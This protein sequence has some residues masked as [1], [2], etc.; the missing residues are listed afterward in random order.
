MFAYF[1]RRL[2]LMIPTF[3]GCTILVFLV[4]QITPGGPIDQI[5][6]QFQMQGTGEISGGGGG[7]AGSGT[8]IPEEALTELKK[9]FDL[10]KPI[11]VRYWNWLTKTLTGDFGK[12]YVYGEPVMDVITSRFPISVYFG[13]IGFILSYLVCIPLGIIKAI[14]NGTP[15]DIASSA[16][17]YAGYAIPGFALGIL[18]L[19]QFGDFGLG[20]FPQA[21]FRSD[22]WDYL[23]FGEKISDQ[24]EHTI[25]P[26]IAYMAGSFAILTVLMK[27]SLLDNLGQDYV[28][29]AFAKGLSEKRVI[30]IHA[31]RN[32]LIPIVTGLSGILGLFLAGS[33]LIEK[34]F[35]IDGIG[36][37][38]YKSVL[39]RDY[40]VMM[41]LLVISV[42]VLLFGNLFRDFLYAA[43]DPRIRFR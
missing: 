11:P 5:R 25:L 15:F 32:S 36:M 27:N 18:L 28:R 35:D 9:H 22:N 19:L 26:I 3:L 17:V 21:G 40:T 39:N 4:L 10:D 12:S 38:G 16:I 14:K 37:L 7:K 30:G 43:V 2:L 1:V 13:L 6:L 33:F 42:F 34:V 41:G 20:W 23:S 24:I 29:T 8:N 31:V